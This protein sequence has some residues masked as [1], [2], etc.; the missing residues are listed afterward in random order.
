MH[1]S[2]ESEE[3]S[4]EDL[5]ISEASLPLCFVSFQFIRENLKA[6]KNQQPLGIDID[7]KEDNENLNQDSSVSQVQLSNS[8]KTSDQMRQ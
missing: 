7:N 1:I 8:I 2:Y 4:V 5:E 3:E 6:I